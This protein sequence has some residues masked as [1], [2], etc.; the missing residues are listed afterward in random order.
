[1]IAHSCKISDPLNADAAYIRAL[2]VCNKDLEQGLK[3]LKAVVISDPDHKKAK[4][5][6][7]RFKIFKEKE[8][9]GNEIKI[10]QFDLI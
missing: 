6:L 7:K 5:M 9:S 10:T 3:S 4:S 2:C 1:M 8:N